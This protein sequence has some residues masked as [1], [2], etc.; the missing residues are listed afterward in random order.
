M[1]NEKNTETEHAMKILF[2]N[3]A[4]SW[5][6]GECWT[7][8]VMDELR[9]RNH[10]VL[11]FSNSQ[12]KLYSKAQQ[13]GI[14]VQTYPVKKLSFLDLAL[15][16]KLKRAVKEVKPDAIILNS[17]FELK[18]IGLAIKA[19]G[20]SKVIF[21]RG[22][23]YPMKMKPSK[24]YLLSTVVSDV[25][26]NSNHV[27]ASIS[28][29][30]KYLKNEPEIIYHGIHPDSLVFSESTTKNIAIV[31][32]LSHEKGVDIAIRVIQKVLLSEPDAKLW[33]LGDGKEKENLIQLATELGVQNSVEFF[34]F[35]DG[36]ENLLSK[37]SMLIMTSRWEGF[38]LVLLEAMKL[39]M[40]CLAFDHL[41]ANEIIIN[42]ET[43]YLIPDMSVDLMAEKII[44]LL[45]NTELSQLMGRKGNDL[46]KN[47]FAIEKSIDQYERIIE[48]R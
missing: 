41:A 45:E 15:F 23:P 30:L 11:L 25:V 33:V 10:S 47:K 35:V 32:R 5:G 12:S 40:P 34:G 37:C 8:M 3:F 13:N 16:F 17:Y 48:R 28:N 24:R 27:K 29:I 19:F 46:L 20:C 39:R 44:H 2:V 38:G 31:G 14:E 21:T 43:G 42:N 22:I 6:G 7:Y 4:K 1:I 18:T 26:V 9:K 36:V